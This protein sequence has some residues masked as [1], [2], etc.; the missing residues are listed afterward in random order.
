M[1]SIPGWI[2]AAVAGSSVAI[3]LCGPVCAADRFVTAVVST[4]P[5][6]YYRLASTSGKSEVGATTYQASGGATSADPGIAG[7]HFVRLDGQDGYILTTQAGGVASAASIMA[8]VNLE[9]LPAEE[10]HFFYVAGES[11]NGN[12]LDLQFELDNVLRF[13]TASGGNLDFIPPLAT[14]VHQWHMIVATV[15]TASRTRVIYWDGKLAASDNIGGIASK[16]GT[17]SIGASTVFGGRFLKG[18][19][20]E[21]ALWDRALTAREIAA[22]W[23]AGKPRT[24]SRTSTRSA[25]AG[26]SPFATTAKIEAGDVSG[27]IQLKREEQIALMFLTAMQQIESDCQSQRKSACTYDQVVSRLRFDPKADPNYI[28]TLAAKGMAWEAHATAKRPG[29]DGFFILSRSVPV[30]EAYYSTSGTASAAD[31]ELTDRSIAGDS[32]VR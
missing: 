17:F 6:A 5:V 22:I 2:T 8:W 24:G 30:T 13:Y 14:L 10:H 15:D 28:Y 12:D 11:E 29:L 27:P 9:G 31:K 32:F 25:P 18:G 23:A 3:L 21:V 16:R 4:H 7:S 19:V 26:Q 20:A 1:F